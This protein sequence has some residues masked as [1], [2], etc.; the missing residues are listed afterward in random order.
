MII[1]WLRAMRRKE[2]KVNRRVKVYLTPLHRAIK[3]RGQHVVFLS[4]LISILCVCVC[5]CRD[6]GE[7]L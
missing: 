6:G 5:V 4:F 1:S 3:K 7:L 2:A